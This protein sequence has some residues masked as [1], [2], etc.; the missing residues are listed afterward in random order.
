[1]CS[2][3]VG[4]GVTHATSSLKDAL[5]LC[6]VPLTALVVCALY[7]QTVTYKVTY[8]VTGEGCSSQTDNTTASSDYTIAKP[9]ISMK[10]VGAYGQGAPQL[11]VL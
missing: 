5:F 7:L 1:M 10:L 11:F 6:W 8:S 4:P 3:W 2:S 9:S